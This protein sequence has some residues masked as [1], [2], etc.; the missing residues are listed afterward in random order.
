MSIPEDQRYYL[1]LKALYYLYE[2]GLTQ[3]EIAKTLH[4]SRVTLG[5]LLQ[6]A[7]D[8]GMIKFEI[9]DVRGEMRTLKL[10]ELIKNRFG[11]REVHLVDCSN[12]SPEETNR[13][14]S[15]MCASFFESVICSGMNIGVT[16]GRTLTGMV[17]NLS[18]NHSIHDLKVY[19][20]LG[21]APD[22]PTFQPNILA[23]RIVQKYDGV[24]HIITAPFLCHSVALCNELK[25]DPYIE[26]ILE[27]SNHLDLIMVG[28]GEQPVYGADHLSDYPF[29]TDIINELVDAGAV[30][31]ICG[32]FFDID[33]KLCET[34]LSHRIISINIENLRQQKM[35]VG[36]GGGEAKVKSI[37]GALNGHYLQVL[38][39][40]VQ[41]A[42]AIM[43]L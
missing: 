14:I 31:D 16:W 38:I 19:T 11:L 5:R 36:T 25:R 8:E 15:S 20:L 24:T 23:Q 35:V 21:S 42:E 39:S 13:R 33:G 7:R 27:E 34:S 9:V 40:D 2:K 22:S 10:E 29:S 28:I 3:T 30:G 41:T 4:I 26:N 37:L 43:A 12:L 32:N 17:D 6:E 1:K 18:E